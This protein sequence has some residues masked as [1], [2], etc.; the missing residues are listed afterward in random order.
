[1]LNDVLRSAT[2][3]YPL[4]IGGFTGI[5]P[6][7]PFAYHNGRKFSNDND[8]SGHNCAVQTGNA[9]DNGGW[10]YNGCWRINLNLQYNPTE[11]GSIALNT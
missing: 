6:T 11:F 3:E 10:W 1:M 5:T 8:Q 2:D 4:T 9:K 7:D